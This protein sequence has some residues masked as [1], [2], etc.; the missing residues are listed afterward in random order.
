MLKPLFDWLKA[1]PNAPAPADLRALEASKE[2]LDRTVVAAE[3]GADEIG[4]VISRMRRTRAKLEKE[5][6]Q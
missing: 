4:R 5:V 6:R 3:E 2:R 1:Q